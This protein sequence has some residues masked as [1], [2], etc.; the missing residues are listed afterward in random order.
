[1]TTYENDS[2]K[3]KKMFYKGKSRKYLFKINIGAGCILI[4]LHFRQK[5]SIIKNNV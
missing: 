3:N 4:N 5:M 1:M 2:S